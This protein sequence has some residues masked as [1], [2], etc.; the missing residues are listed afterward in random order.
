[1]Q[2]L[3]DRIAQLEKQLNPDRKTPYACKLHAVVE[4]DT[5][6]VLADLYFQV[7]QPRSSTLLGFK[8]TV[9]GDA[10]LRP[11]GSDGP[12]QM[13]MVERNK[14]EGYA[15]Q[16]DKPG[17]YQLILELKLPVAGGGAGPGAERGFDLFLPGAAVTTLTLQLPEAVHEMRWNKTTEKLPADQ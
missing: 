4:G 7:E 17:D 1:Y 9:L 2:E 15:V 3:K 8:G 5:V 11:Q 10:K 14:D 13:A 12:W 6:R 16:V